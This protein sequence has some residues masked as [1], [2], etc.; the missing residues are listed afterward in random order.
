M[1]R[2]HFYPGNQ[3]II[4][5]Q[6][7]TIRVHTLTPYPLSHDAGEGKSSAVRRV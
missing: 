1:E 6:V 3:T 7:S 4:A 2:S 5:Y